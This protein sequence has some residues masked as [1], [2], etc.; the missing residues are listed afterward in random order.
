MAL[1]VLIDLAEQGRGAVSPPLER[2]AAACRLRKLVRE[3]AKIEKKNIAGLGQTAGELS[4]KLRLGVRAVRAY[5]LGRRR[6]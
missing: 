4:L 2:W 5:G 3:K 6:C 1:E